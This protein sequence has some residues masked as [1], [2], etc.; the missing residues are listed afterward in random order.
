MKLMLLCQ[1]VLFVTK[2]E[3]CNYREELIQNRFTNLVLIGIWKENIR[4]QLCPILKLNS[5][6]D[7]ELLENLSLAMSGKHEHFNKLINTEL[8]F[9]LSKPLRRQKN[10]EKPENKLFIELQS[11]KFFLDK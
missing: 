6:S 9:L 10:P 7:K 3:R 8:I 11:S 1:K 5:L 4:N 2:E